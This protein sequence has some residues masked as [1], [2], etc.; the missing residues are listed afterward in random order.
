MRNESGSHYPQD[1]RKTPV[2]KPLRPTLWLGILHIGQ[3][4]D[5]L[6]PD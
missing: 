3:N 2:P 1:G 5:Y 4:S 6:I